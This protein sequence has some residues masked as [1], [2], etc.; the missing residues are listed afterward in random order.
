M[1]GSRRLLIVGWDAADWKIIHP[2]ME[3]GLMPHT[4]RLVERGASGNLATL[5]PVLSPM[6]WT[7]IATGKRPHQHGIFG[8]SEPTPDGKGVQPIS[9]PSRQTKAFWNILNQQGWQSQVVGWWPSHPVEPINGAMVSNHY[10]R[11]T[12]PLAQGWPMAPGTVHP[13]RLAEPLAALR[14]HPEELTAD[15]I[16]PFVPHLEAVDQDRDGRLA[17]LMRIV[18][19]CTTIH[20]AATYLLEHEPWD[21]AAVYYDAI[22]HFC[23]GFM[24]YHPP[25][26][27]W[28]TESDFRL[29]QNVVAAG[30]V[31]HDMML[32]RLLEL[33]GPETLVVLC[34]DHG[35]HPDHLR[36]SALPTEPA[37]PAVEHRDFGVLALAGPNIA[38]DRLLHGANLLDITPTCLA[39]LG[40]AVG[41]DM[42][43]RVLTDAFVE[44]PAVTTVPSWDAIPGDDAR[45]QNRPPAAPGEA[46]EAMRQLEDLGYVDPLPE[47]QERAVAQTLRELEY[48]RARSYQDAGRHGDAL[49]ILIRLYTDYPLEFRFGIQLALSLQALGRPAD[50]GRVVEDMGRRWARAAELAAERLQTI[51]G[52]AAER[53]AARG[54]AEL[55]AGDA[56]AEADAEANAPVFNERE[57]RVVREL[58]AIARGNRRSLDYL[59]AAAATAQGQHAEALEHLERARQSETQVPG[60]HIQLGE[61]YRRLRRPAE[62]VACYERALEQ[63]PENPA[64][65]LGRARAY[66][67]QGEATAARQAAEQA[68]ALK[69]HNPVAHFVDGVARQQLG[70]AAGAIAALERAI[71]QNPNFPQAH[72]MLARIHARAAG[73]NPSLPAF[74]H[75]ARARALRQAA[76][77]HRAT[78][79]AIPLPALEA[80]PFAPNLPDF[81][82]PSTPPAGRHPSLR[83]GPAPE[84][85]EMPPVVIVSGLPRSGTSM[86]MQM[87]E[88]GGWPVYCDGVRAADASNP[89]GYYECEAV[90][91]LGTCN[92]WLGTVGG[93]ALKVVAP[94]LPE[95]PRDCRYRVLFLERNLDEIIASQGRMLARLERQ[96]ADLQANRLREALARQQQGALAVLERT[97]QPVL[98][99]GHRAVIDAPATASARIAQFLEVSLDEPA[100]RAVVDPE[101]HRERLG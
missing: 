17:A 74:E 12:G 40:L 79:V 49:P 89:R 13:P 80:I 73:A 7:S 9:G 60:F 93:Q 95:L 83:H 55:D 88:A 32:G 72:R 64:A 82:K 25:R 52:I 68:L 3:Q 37:G 62:A 84:V 96:G 75:R 90:K 6:L 43:G 47:N 5:S 101:L 59:A 98:R 34:S 69:Y 99:L 66:L 31:Y 57:R 44:P 28:V 36:P 8:F 41:E 38:Q 63:D 65:H 56:E 23:H 39:A 58:R 4:R 46:R 21:V 10:Q 70:D 26:Q 30:Y 67:R 1:T 86:L 78:P 94:L 85:P 42:D 77:E 76:R 45:P 91:R 61:T 18:A 87:L 2:L 92:D 81:P 19:D 24:K 100:M 97:A 29:Y 54:L 48:N 53:R 11:A 14:L 16:R 22:D 35:F 71:D 33:T 27:P 15:V 20:S 51:R 50:M